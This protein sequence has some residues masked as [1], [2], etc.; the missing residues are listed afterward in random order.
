MKFFQTQT[1]LGLDIVVAAL[2]IRIHERSFFCRFYYVIAEI[3]ALY[4]YTKIVLTM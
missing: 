1:C 3:N 4:A 2:T